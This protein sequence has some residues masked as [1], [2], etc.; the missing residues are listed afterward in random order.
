MAKP[1]TYVARS[2]TG[3]T[4]VNAIPTATSHFSLW[5]GEVAG[6][7]TYTIT[8]VGFTTT[9]SAAATMI[10]QLLAHCSVSAGTVIVGTVA[11]GP[12]ATD[13]IAGGSRAVVASTVTISAANGVWHPVGMSVNSAALTATIGLGTYQQ[14]RGLYYLPPGGIFSLAVLG[15]TAAGTSQFSIQ[16]EEG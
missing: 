8:A 10:V 4:A 15:S 12:I 7:K 9:A 14:V 13:G 3:V 2:V 6:G 5:N 11:S 1:R 16:W